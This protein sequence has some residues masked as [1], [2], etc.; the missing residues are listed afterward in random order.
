MGAACHYFDEGD[1]VLNVSFVEHIKT[2]ARGGPYRIISISKR[3]EVEAFTEDLT[4]NPETKT[5]R[6]IIRGAIQIIRSDEVEA[7]IWTF[8]KRYEAP[9]M[10]S[11][12]DPVGLWQSMASTTQFLLQWS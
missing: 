3:G 5:G 6:R 9:T 2:K 10:V 7:G 11:D 4:M 8:N 12:D 1:T